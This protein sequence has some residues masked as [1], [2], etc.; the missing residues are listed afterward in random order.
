MPRFDGPL[1]AFE[2]CH[3]ERPRA[4]AQQRKPCRL[5]AGPLIISERDPSNVGAIAGFLRRDVREPQVIDLVLVDA[6]GGTEIAIPV[7]LLRT[8]PVPFDI[9]QCAVHAHLHAE[10]WQV[11]DCAFA[12][13]E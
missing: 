8:A 13:F 5:Q 12:G 1:A 10:A 11:G 9:S 7:V 6:D 2:F 3:A 4:E